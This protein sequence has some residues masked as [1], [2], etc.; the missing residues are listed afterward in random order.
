MFPI[1]RDQSRGTLR[2]E[3][4][5]IEY[6]SSH[7]HVTILAVCRITRGIPRSRDSGEHSLSQA[8]DSEAIERD[9]DFTKEE[10]LD[11]SQVIIMDTFKSLANIYLTF[12][13][14]E[15]RTSFLRHH[16]KT[17]KKHD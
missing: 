4:H 10:V 17:I 13:N 1:P 8:M 3:G 15:L 9:K 6:M 2:L 12:K 14:K 5:T 16:M 7:G 11:A